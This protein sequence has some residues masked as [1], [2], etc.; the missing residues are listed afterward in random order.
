MYCF[1]SSKFLAD[2]LKT[3]KVTKEKNIGIDI[4]TIIKDLEQ[5]SIYKYL[6]IN[7]GKGM[8]HAKIMNK[9]EKS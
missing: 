4:D 6:G 8:Q 9:H 5:E 1:H 3:S 7:E 2:S